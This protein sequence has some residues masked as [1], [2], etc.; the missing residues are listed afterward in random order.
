MAFGVLKSMRDF[1]LL[2]IDYGNII[3][4]WRNSISILFHGPLNETSA[5][6]WPTRAAAARA[7][8]AGVEESPDF[9]E[10]GDC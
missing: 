10:Q 6:I 5:T 7:H 8:A 3:D 1:F 9:T 4:F 2:E